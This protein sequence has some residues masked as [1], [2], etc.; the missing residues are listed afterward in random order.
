MRFADAKMLLPIALDL[1]LTNGAS[2]YVAAAGQD[3][4]APIRIL[5]PQ[6]SVEVEPTSQPTQDL[7]ARRDATV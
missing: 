5:D 3:L 7:T 1:S 2:V 6:V 4:P